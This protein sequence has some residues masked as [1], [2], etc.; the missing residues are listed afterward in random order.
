MGS[1]PN[2]LKNHSSETQV[3]TTPA[4]RCP[5]ISSN[6][7]SIL[8]DSSDIKLSPQ[9]RTF[10]LLRC[11]M[12]SLRSWKIAVLVSLDGEILW[13]SLSVRRGSCSL[14][15]ESE[16]EREAKPRPQPTTTP[17]LS[18]FLARFASLRSVDSHAMLRMLS[19]LTHL[20]LNLK[21]NCQQQTS[22]ISPFSS[23]NVN[24]N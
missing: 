23:D 20:K 12:L 19:S 21:L 6:R 18:F 10:D 3:Q 4:L 17:T 11:I 13:L 1:F 22:P 15:R 24:P 14:R 16:R 8:K 9:H 2:R 5:F 7:T